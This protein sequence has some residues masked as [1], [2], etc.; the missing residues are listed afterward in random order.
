LFWFSAT[1]SSF[2]YKVRQILLHQFV[3]FGNGLFETI[4]GGAGDVEVK[5]WVLGSVSD[6]SKTVRWTKKLT[7]A[8]AIAL[9]G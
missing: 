6:T 3:N 9:S 5:G 2:V 1:E 4:S 7:A 8:V